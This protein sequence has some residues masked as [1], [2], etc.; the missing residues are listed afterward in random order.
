MAGLARLVIV[1]FA[2][3]SLAAHSPLPSFLMI[4]GDDIGELVEDA[5]IF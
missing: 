2:A 1:A 5:H 4:L 3:V